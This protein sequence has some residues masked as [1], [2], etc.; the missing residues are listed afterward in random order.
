L[1]GEINNADGDFLLGRRA[2]D[3]RAS[4]CGCARFVLRQLTR[5]VERRTCPI[6]Y[7]GSTKDER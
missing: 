4:L 6:G 7:F 5:I 1:E 2:R 3:R